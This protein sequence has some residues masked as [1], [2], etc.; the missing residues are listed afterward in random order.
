MTD[1]RSNYAS[2]AGGVESNV[3]VLDEAR[4][5]NSSLRRVN[6]QV[7]MNVMQAE[8]ASEMLDQDGSTIEKSLHNHKYELKGALSST[9]NRMSKIKNAERNEKY[10]MSLAILFF[11]SVVSYILLKRFGLLSQFW[12]IV[13]CKSW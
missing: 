13:G 9:S 1:S 6:Q 10:Y 5:I 7:R 12:Y 8:S 3:G 11:T 2:S 4:L